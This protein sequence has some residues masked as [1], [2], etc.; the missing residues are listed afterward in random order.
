[1]SFIS[2][3]FFS[4]ILDKIL[5]LLMTPNKSSPLTKQISSFITDPK[6]FLYSNRS[7]LFNCLFRILLKLLILKQLINSLISSLTNF[8]II[9]VFK[10]LIFLVVEDWFTLTLR[11][12]D[13]RLWLCWGFCLC[14]CFGGLGSAE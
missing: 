14:R 1:M 6:L 4:L 7:S 11:L 9:F 8:L 13:G 3:S 12:G 5:G 10:G 2:G